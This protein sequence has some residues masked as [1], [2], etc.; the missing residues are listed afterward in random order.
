M[1]VCA[2]MKH[3]QVCASMYKYVLV[4]ASVPVGKSG[5]GWA[6]VIIEIKSKIQCVHARPY[7]YYESKS[8]KIGSVSVFHEK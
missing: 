3:V 2:S 7:L 4:C 1:E 5:Q 8:M 6:I